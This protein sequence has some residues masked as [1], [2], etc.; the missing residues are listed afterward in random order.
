M[1]V[2]ELFKPDPSL[3]PAEALKRRAEGH[4]RLLWPAYPVTLTILALAMLLSGEFNRRGHWQRIALSALI[5]AALLFCAVGL[6]GTMALNAGVVPLGYLNLILPILVCG[7][8]LGDRI[9]R[10]KA[11]PARQGAAP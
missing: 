9:P 7:W 8:M 3:T 4:Q 6:R 2:D 11:A 1:F 10:Q 5:G